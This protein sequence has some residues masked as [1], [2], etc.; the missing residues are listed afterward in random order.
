VR[1]EIV[2]GLLHVRDAEDGVIRRAH[3]ACSLSVSCGLGCFQLS[4]GPAL[5]LI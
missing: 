4:T 3:D 5:K 2:G 1:T